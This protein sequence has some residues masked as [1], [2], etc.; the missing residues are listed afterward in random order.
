MSRAQAQA[1]AQARPRALPCA[2]PTLKLESP[3][4]HSVP[5]APACALWTRLLPLALVSPPPDGHGLEGEKVHVPHLCALH[6]AALC[7]AVDQRQQAAQPLSLE[8]QL[9]LLRGGAAG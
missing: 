4:L 2:Y 9:Q 8:S 3:P 7:L 1:Q 6:P 5:E